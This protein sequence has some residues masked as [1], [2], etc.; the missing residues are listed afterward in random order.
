MATVT[1]EKSNGVTH[2]TLNKPTLN[3]I[4]VAMTEEIDAALQSLKDDRATKV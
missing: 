4:D 3:V 1:I 2:V